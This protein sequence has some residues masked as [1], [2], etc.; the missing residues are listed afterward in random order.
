MTA[1]LAPEPLET[2]VE[3]EEAPPLVVFVDDEPHVLAALRRLLRTEPYEL[4][5]LEDPVEA[6]DLTG[7]RDVRLIISDQRMP[8]MSGAELLRCVRD[9][10]PSTTRV[11]LTAYPDSAVNEDRTNRVIQR[12][13]TKPWDD[14]QFKGMIRQLISWRE[15]P[16]GVEAAPPPVE[17]F[18]DPDRGAEELGLRLD[19][20]HQDGPEIL[21]PILEL[22][23]RPH[24][25]FTGLAI[26]S[27]RLDLLRDS[28][29]AFLQE[30]L[31]QVEIH[32]VSTGIIDTSG[33]AAAFLGGLGHPAPLMAYR[34]PS[35]HPRP[36]RVLAIGPR[37]PARAFLK[38]IVE[39]A[40]HRCRTACSVVNGVAMLAEQPFDLLL[41]DL[42]PPAADGIDLLTRLGSSHRSMPVVGLAT[43]LDRWD[44]TNLRRVGVP[45]ALVRPWRV[46]HV[47]EAIENAPVS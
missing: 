37:P 45:R 29:E 23:R 31:R 30:L 35:T 22:L 28:V 26:L 17:G 33:R 25:I 8:R 44:E 39:T 10:S 42:H 40:G 9:R 34:L 14:G 41:M 5:T 6:L 38:A 20:A 46:R 32:G 21:G 2:R 18:T 43:R 27:E 24:A 3:P 36:R 47:L 12:L 7:S 4:V 13:V 16:P 1:T 11:I 19:C 15:G